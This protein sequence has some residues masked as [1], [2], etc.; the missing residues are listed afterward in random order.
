MRV[1]VVYHMFPHYRGAVMHALDQSERHNYT[2][3]G[4]LEAYNGIEPVDPRIFKRMIRAPSYIY[5]GLFWQPMATKVALSSNYDVLIYLGNPNFISTWVGALLGRL[6]GKRVLFWT[7]GW[8]RP[9][10]WL[11][12]VIR[13]LFHRLAHQVLV[14]GERAKA[15]GVA[16]G[17]PERRITV[18]YNSLDFA[19][20]QKVI[21]SIENG[22]VA[23]DPRSLFADPAH[24]ILIATARLTGLCRFDLLLEAAERL[25]ARNLCV[26]ILLVGDGPECGPLEAMARDK[27]INLCL[28][29]ACYDE[30]VL[31]GLIYASDLTVSPGKVGLTAVHSLMY[32]TPV[33]THSDLDTQMPEVEAIVDGE[34]GALFARDDVDDLTRTIET[35]LSRDID[36]A[37]LRAACR[38]M[39]ALK[40]NPTTQVCLIESAIDGADA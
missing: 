26:N 16:S 34:T 14:Y 5:R 12:S 6:T 9:E 4:S 35:W 20:A 25:R 15:L 3:Y 23:V 28:F 10:A 22:K 21:A 33:I 32:G 2:F 40:W 31:G 38:R 18:I 13:G 24:P 17:Y 11:R 8:L 7:H 39:I 37:K 36:R 1:A 29:G 30:T 19:R 27:K